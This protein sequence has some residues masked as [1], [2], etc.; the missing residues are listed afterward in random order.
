MLISNECLRLQQTVKLRQR[1]FE[2]ETNEQENNDAAKKI[3]V[4]ILTDWNKQT[5]WIQN[6]NQNISRFNYCYVPVKRQG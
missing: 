4:T 2:C 5:T 6:A 3:Q 1:W